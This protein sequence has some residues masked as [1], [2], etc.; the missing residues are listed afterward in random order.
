M[1]PKAAFGAEFFR[2]AVEGCVFDADGRSAGEAGFG[3]FALLFS[4]D[5]GPVVGGHCL[6]WVGAVLE[7]VVWEI[8]AERFSLRFLAFV[9][10]KWRE[11]KMLSN[12]QQTGDS[13]SYLCVNA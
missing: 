2:D 1:F 6:W 12:A 5:E 3:N 9:L 4:G 10:W 7:T 8:Y 11:D 13:A